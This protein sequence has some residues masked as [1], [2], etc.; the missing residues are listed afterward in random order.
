MTGAEAVERFPEARFVSGYFDPVLASHAARLEE[1]AA[2]RALVVVLADPPDP[3]L[4]ALSRGQLL[5]GLRSVSA[6]VL[7]GDPVAE[8]RVDAREEAADIVR[9]S[10][11]V[12]R[13]HGR[14]AG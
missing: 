12:E 8:P 10:G 13:V 2:G 3:L 11:L 4:P 1:L 14:H 6:V 5:S 7:P 9:R